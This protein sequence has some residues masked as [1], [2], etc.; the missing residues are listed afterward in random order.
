MSYLTMQNIFDSA[1]KQA[2][3]KLRCVDPVENTCCYRSGSNKCFIGAVIP[4]D[5]YSPKLEGRVGT[6][7]L[8][9]LGL[10]RPGDD[11]TLGLVCEVQRIHDSAPVC[12][13]SE[14][15]AELATKYKLVAPE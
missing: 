1:W 7:V 5:K 12:A 10:V 6:A 2:A 4:A 9:E 8:I 14:E 15:L 3:L 13:W 11:Q